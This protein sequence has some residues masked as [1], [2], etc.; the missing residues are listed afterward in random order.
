MGGKLGLWTGELD[1][2]RDQ[3][4]GHRQEFMGLE[5]TTKMRTDP[6]SRVTNA[7]YAGQRRPGPVMRVNDD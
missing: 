7:A 1:S 5:L 6:L 4:L 2:L 3:P